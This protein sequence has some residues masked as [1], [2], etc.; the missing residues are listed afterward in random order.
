MIMKECTKC[1]IAQPD[2]NYHKDIS[3]KDGLCVVCKNCKISQVTEYYNK[4]RESCNE[5]KKIRHEKNKNEINLRRRKHSDFE[6][7]GTYNKLNP[8]HFDFG[9][10]LRKPLG[11]SN[12]NRLLRQYKRQAKHRRFEFNLSE[13]EFKALTSGNCF[14]CG[15]EPRQIMK[16]KDANGGFVYNG[17]DRIDNAVGYTTTNCVSCCKLCNRAKGSL[18]QKE[19]QEWVCRLIAYNTTPA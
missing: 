5:K 16:N 15:I 3:K 17:I 4:N 19:W 13:I 7:R 2:T 11:V 10:S 6:G 12:Y 8:Q 9:A 18:S 1:K 14:Y